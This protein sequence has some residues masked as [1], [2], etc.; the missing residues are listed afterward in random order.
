METPGKTGVFPT[1]CDAAG[2]AVARLCHG[3]GMGGPCIFCGIIRGEIP[4]S[5]VLRGD[6]VCAFLDSRPVFKGHV[7]VVPSTHYDDFP[8]LPAAEMGPYWTAFQRISRAVEAGLVADGTVFRL[9]N[10]LS[11]S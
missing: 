6:G 9:S 5:F 3:T 11:Q 4:A 10:K 7:L 8:A 1:A 2:K